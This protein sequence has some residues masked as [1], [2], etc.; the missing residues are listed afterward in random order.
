MGAAGNRIDPAT[1]K[2]DGMTLDPSASYRVT[3]NN[4]LGGGGDDLPIF[5]RGTGEVTGADDLVALEAYLDANDPYA[6][7]TGC[8]SR[9]STRSASRQHTVKAGLQGPA[10]TSSFEGEPIERERGKRK[11]L[12]SQSHE[13]QRRVVRGGSV[14]VQ[15]AAA[16]ASVNEDPLP[17]T[18]HGDG[19]RLHAGAALVEHGPIAG[20]IVDV[21]APQACRAMIAMLRA[22]GV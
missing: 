16:G 11:R 13:Q 20:P 18:T 8:E 5:K 2:L 10:F 9:A 17:P 15:L 19:D 21:S 6:P 22:G 3:M 1:I 4:F 12:H 14:R 7:V